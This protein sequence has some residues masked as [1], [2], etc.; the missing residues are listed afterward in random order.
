MSQPTEATIDGS[1]P[2]SVNI[3]YHAY[4]YLM[5]LIAM[6]IEIWSHAKSGRFTAAESLVAQS[7]IYAID[8]RTYHSI[9]SVNRL[10]H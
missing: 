1:A 5:C 8:W 9:D 2:H 3:L 10:K 4:V 7:A 6:F